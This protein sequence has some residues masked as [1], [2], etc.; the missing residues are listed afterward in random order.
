M[1][2]DGGVEENALFLTAK[3]EHVLQ[4]MHC[5]KFVML[6]NASHVQNRRCRASNRPAELDLRVAQRLH[7]QIPFDQRDG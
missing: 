2:G 7:D 6:S 4:A 3:V 1:V 5:H